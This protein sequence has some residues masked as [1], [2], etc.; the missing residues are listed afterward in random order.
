ML[1]EVLALAT[2]AAAG[3]S[4]QERRRAAAMAAMGH[5][6]ALLGR[7]GV[8]AYLEF[9][10]SIPD[11][12]A[13]NAATSALNQSYYQ[14]AQEIHEFVDFEAV[15]VRHIRGGASVLGWESEDADVYSE[16]E[17]DSDWYWVGEDELL[18]W[19]KE[20]GK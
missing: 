14:A 4:D 5:W 15:D 19:A 11:G 13:R 9:I 7:L 1:I 16:D 12:E 18:S 20:R 2:L 3:M 10:S 6:D 8:S 17:I